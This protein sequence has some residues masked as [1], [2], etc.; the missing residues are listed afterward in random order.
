M[1][2]FNVGDTVR[3]RQ[4]D[5]M[6]REF[7]LDLDGCIDC[8]HTFISDMKDLCGLTFQIADEVNNGTI[9]RI[10]GFTIS[11]DMVEL[12]KEEQLDADTSAIESYLA[13]LTVASTKEG[14][15]K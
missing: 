8:Q 9:G 5:D 13:T 7:G 11:E 4:W 14:A 6:E 2:R 12:V 10:R 15:D 1:G 3:I